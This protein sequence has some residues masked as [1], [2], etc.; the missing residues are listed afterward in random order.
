[1]QV[2]LVSERNTTKT[3]PACGHRYK[4][5]GRIYRC[6]NPQ[7]T[8][9]FHRDGVGAIN[10]RQTYTGSGLVVGAMASPTGVR[11]HAHLS[12]SS[13]LRHRERIPAL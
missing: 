12:R 9:V 7:C 5:N 3:C 13:A 8:F 2:V 1:M 4:P 11:Y 10:I 6:R